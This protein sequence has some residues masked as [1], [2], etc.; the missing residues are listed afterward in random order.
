MEHAATIK[1]LHKAYWQTVGMISKAD[2]NETAKIR[3][4]QQ[5]FSKR[6]AELTEDI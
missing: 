6:K 5:A 2:P 4:A 3:N 1:E